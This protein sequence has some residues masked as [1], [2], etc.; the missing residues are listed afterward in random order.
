MITIHDVQNQ[1]FN[2]SDEYGLQFM[3]NPEAIA[4]MGSNRVIIPKLDDFSLN[5]FSSKEEAL[6]AY[7][8]VLAKG[9]RSMFRKKPANITPEQAAFAFDYF[10]GIV[11]QHVTKVPQW[12]ETLY[13]YED[14]PSGHRIRISLTHKSFP[15]MP[16]WMIDECEQRVP[17]LRTV[18]EDCVNGINTR[19]AAAGLGPLTM[20]TKYVDK[21]QSASY[22]FVAPAK[23]DTI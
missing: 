7:T 1:T 21:V 18:L 23:Q 5:S 8:T 15:N 11:C 2:P 19:R 16:M 22:L 12:L 9:N 4:V 20:K 17:F 14:T 13:Q 10:L 6:A 3:K